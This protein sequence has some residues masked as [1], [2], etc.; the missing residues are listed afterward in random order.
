MELVD[1]QHNIDQYRQ[2]MQKYNISDVSLL[3]T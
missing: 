1:A 3:E 2:V